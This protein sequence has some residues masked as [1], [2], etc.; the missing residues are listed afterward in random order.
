MK[1]LL[2]PFVCASL[3]AASSSQAVAVFGIN[4][5]AGPNGSLVQFDSATPGAV[6]TIG[7]LSQPLVDIDFFPAN[8]LLYGITST[9][10][11]YTVNLLT[12]ALT[13]RFSPLTAITGLTDLDFNPVADRMRLFG[14]TDQNY[15]MV[16]D[17]TTEK[18]AGKQENRCALFQASRRHYATMQL[19]VE[20]DVPI[21]LV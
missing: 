20:P 16:P 11:T 3:G 17:F 12:A 19:E 15:R 7:T 10:D 13:F 8:G 6:A 14:N 5:T 18:F 1:K 9:G 2:L 21:G 4:P